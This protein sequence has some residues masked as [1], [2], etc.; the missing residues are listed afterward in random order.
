MTNHLKGVSRLPSVS[1]TEPVEALD[2]TSRIFDCLS[3]GRFPNT[4]FKLPM[5]GS[6]IVDVTNFVGGSN[7]QALAA[8]LEEIGEPTGR[9]NIWHIDHLGRARIWATK[10]WGFVFDPS[11]AKEW[12]GPK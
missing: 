12:Q 6:I 4:L 7:T 8:L 5:D 1:P 11:D 2:A 10:A 9:K 3:T